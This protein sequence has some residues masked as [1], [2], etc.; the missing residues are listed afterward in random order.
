VAN[1]SVT[2]VIS[3][4]QRRGAEMFAADLALD[5]GRRG[6][7]SDV[8]A[9]TAGGDGEPLP[10]P[11]LGRR[12]FDPSTLRALRRA[13]GSAG[14]VVA[15]GSRTLPACGLA[16]VGAGVP[17][18]YRSIGDP[19]V[20]SAT[21]A[22]RMRTAV[23]LRRARIVTVLWTGAADVL[24]RGRAVP[25]GRIRVVPNGVDAARCPVPDAFDRLLARERFRL[26]ADAPVL[27]YLG[28]LTGEKQVDAVIT[29][30]ARIP[31][32]FLLVAG[33]GPE[34]A[35]LQTLAAREA[36]S[37]VHFVGTVADPAFAYAAA[38][39]VI[40]ASRTEGMPGVLIEAALSGLPAV[41]FD[42]G[43]V[44]EVV[45][46][47]ETGIVVPPGD[48]AAL[49]TGAKQVLRDAAAMGAAARRRCLDRFE[50]G[51]VGAQWAEVLNEVM[52]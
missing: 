6:I 46:D 13:S 17:F 14:A 21:T 30:V 20:W 3:S 5:L 23:L 9:L 32:A 37:R 48:V 12:P 11:V 27:A 33:S 45:A 4:T 2:H 31:G 10:F 28:S 19:A 52:G 38:D 8:V 25:P 51:V 47:G 40:L 16:L 1:R 18:V 35:G 43:A 49:V 42:V 34:R 36:R 22:R 7:A 29:A 44:A 24:T 41:A 26:P 50:I 39:A 15:H